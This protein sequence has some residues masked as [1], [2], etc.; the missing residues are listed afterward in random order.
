V[1]VTR[2]LALSVQSTLQILTTSLPIGQIGSITQTP[3]MA[4]GGIPPYIWRANSPGFDP[5][6]IGI[7]LE[8]GNVIVED[9]TQPVN[10]TAVIHLT[11]SERLP[12]FKDLTT[13][14]I[15]LP[16]AFP[17]TTTLSSS[18][19][20]AGTSDSVTFTAKVVQ[21]S[22]VPAGTVVFFSGGNTMIGNAVLD[23]NGSA[24]IQTSF[25]T[26]GVYSITAVFG[27]STSSGGSTST[28]LSEAVVTPSITTSVNPGTL[29]I[30]SGSSG[31]LT[32]TLTPA[33]D[34]TGTVT[35]SCG[36]LPAHVS[37]S[38]APASIPIAAGSGPVTDTLTVHTDAPQTAMLLKPHNSGVP[39]N[40]SAA[41]ILWLPGSL[42]GMLVLIPRRRT[43][44]R[45]G[46]SQVVLVLC[47]FCV[48][49][50]VSCGG[51][52]SNPPS[53]N[54]ASHGTYIIPITLSIGGGGTQNVNATV[55]ID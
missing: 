6:V 27:G 37:C 12:D 41:A 22:G 23:P 28:P 13:P 38:F 48:A 52:P 46:K 15:F 26:P 36:T 49:A 50:L 29:T 45:A 20:A 14:L 2:T 18:N 44:A 7:F 8:D 40:T 10:G 35:F 34:F 42:L 25:A 19:T 16:A 47:L 32:L 3:L 4:T 9:P 39:N 51:G 43:W 21:T 55:V 17:T 33:G 53:T 11:D 30:K 31:K 54:D 24:S 1:K 5:N